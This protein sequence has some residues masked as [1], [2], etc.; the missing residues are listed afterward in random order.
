VQVFLHLVTAE[1][2]IMSKVISLS[3][4]IDRFVHD[5]DVVMATHSFRSPPHEII[6]IAE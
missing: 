5:G 1:G 2:T 3:A 4:A 6:V